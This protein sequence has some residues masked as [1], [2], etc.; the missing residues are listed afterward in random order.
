MNEKLTGSGKWFFTV[1]PNRA[2]V[3]SPERGAF[4]H[5]QSACFAE[6]ERP[7]PN[8]L[9]RLRSITPSPGVRIVTATED[10]HSFVLR[11]GEKNGS[12]VE[13]SL[14]FPKNLFSKI[15]WAGKN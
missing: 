15:R 14:A 7:L 5:G 1:V 12:S 6:A 13:F 9:L 10:G 11:E 4:E 8:P 2:P 3:G